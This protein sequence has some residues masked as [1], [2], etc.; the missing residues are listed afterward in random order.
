MLVLRIEGDE[1]DG[2]L[3]QVCRYILIHVESEHFRVQLLTLP[4][5]TRIVQQPLLIQ[6]IDRAL[7]TSWPCCLQVAVSE[8]PGRILA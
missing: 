3:I 2:R 6:P 8:A 4:L 1:E 7:V 5:M